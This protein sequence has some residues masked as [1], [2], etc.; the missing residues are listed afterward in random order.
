MLLKRKTDRNSKTVKDTAK[1]T[2]NH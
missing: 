1:I 2:I